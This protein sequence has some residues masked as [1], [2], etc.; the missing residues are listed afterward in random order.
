MAAEINSGERIVILSRNRIEF[1]I[2]A[3]RAG[4]RESQK[5]ASGHVD[6]IINDVGQHLFLV[7]VAGAPF[8]DGHDAGGNHF[9]WIEPGRLIRRQNVT[10]DLLPDELVIRQIAVEGVYDPV[11]IPIRLGHVRFAADAARIERVGVANDIEPV[12]A[13]TLAV[14]RQGQQAV[15]DFGESIR[16]IVR[17]K[18]FDFPGRRRQANQIERRAPNQCSLVGGWRRCESIAFE[19]RQ[20]EIIHRRL[21]P[22]AIF[23]RWHRRIFDGLKGPPRLDLRFAICDLRFFSSRIRRAHP[24]P[25]DKVGDLFVAEFALFRRRH[26]QVFVFVTNRLDEQTF[27]IVARHHARFAGLAAFQHPFPAVEPQIAFDLFAPRAV[28]FVAAL[29][30]HRSDFLFEKL[31][32]S[33]QTRGNRVKSRSHQKTDQQFCTRAAD[34]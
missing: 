9:A 12:S 31:N 30:Q 3:A 27:V 1:M 7:G 25:G 24:H 2:V 34:G 18:R 16:R 17:E 26:L 21:D 33:G 32:V 4:E 11:A 13:P 23:H 14:M 19:F 8:A 29:N 15:H 20:N 10:G 22:G 28:A 6:L 5:S